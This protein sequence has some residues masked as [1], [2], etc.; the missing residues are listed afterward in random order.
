MLGS[1][2]SEVLDRGNASSFDLL[3]T[4]EKTEKILVARSILLFCEKQFSLSSLRPFNNKKEIRSK[5]KNL[6][7]LYVI[8]NVK[9]RE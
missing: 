3:L 4:I 7:K 8:D 5:K 2:S 6:D 1:W 9:M